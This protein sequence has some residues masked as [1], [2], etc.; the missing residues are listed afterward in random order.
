MVVA[1]QGPRQSPR[2]FLSASEKEAEVT[3]LASLSLEDRGSHSLFH[4]FTPSTVY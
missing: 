4:S 2:E 3:V 1:E